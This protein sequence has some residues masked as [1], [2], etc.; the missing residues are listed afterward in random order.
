MTN[1]KVTLPDRNAS[2]DIMRLLASIAVVAIHTYP[3]KSYG[4]T[5]D[6]VRYA[7]CTWAVPFFFT[8]TGYYFD[9]NNENRAL[10][11]LWLM[12]RLYFIWTLIYFP[13][14]F[15]RKIYK[16]E[17]IMHAIL[18]E[19]KDILFV[20]SYFQLWY[21]V[22]MIWSLLL[23][24]LI[25]RFKRGENLVFVIATL[26]YFLNCMISNYNLQLEESV[27]KI[28]LFWGNG[29]NFLCMGLPF[30]F[31]GMKARSKLFDVKNR[32]IFFMVSV[33]LWV[34]ESFF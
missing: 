6:M 13:I 30:I 33:A 34:M 21:F 15:V 8:V 10:V 5:I 18:E 24:L 9:I 26:F 22:A 2:I 29:L 20:G 11:K 23:L 31:V 32:K 25:I 3:F 28:W 27:K 1:R 7:F 19:I 12:M 14:I 4:S 17:N 16:Q